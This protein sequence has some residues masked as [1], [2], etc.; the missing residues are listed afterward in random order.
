MTVL[1]RIAKSGETLVANTSAIFDTDNVVG[2]NDPATEHDDD[3]VGLIFAY[4]WIRLEDGATN[5]ADGTALL[6]DDVVIEG[7]TSS[8]YELTDDD[9]GDTFALQVWVI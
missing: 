2:T 4:Q 3:D 6:D 5:N 7:A 9:V 1:T 8:T